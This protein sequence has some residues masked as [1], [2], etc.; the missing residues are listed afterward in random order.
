MHKSSQLLIQSPVALGLFP[1]C[2]TVTNKYINAKHSNRNKA[3]Y[4]IPVVARYQLKVQ[5]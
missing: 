2:L 3:K 5:I 1:V 4:D